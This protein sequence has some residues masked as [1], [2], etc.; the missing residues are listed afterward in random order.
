MI[1][2]YFWNTKLVSP[3][4]KSDFCEMVLQDP[5]PDNL[6]NVIDVFRVGGAGEVVVE[7]PLTFFRQQ[8]REPGLGSRLQKGFLIRHRLSCK[9]N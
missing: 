2:F 5:L 3:L 8:L 7:I 9:I 4:S 6:E 1:V